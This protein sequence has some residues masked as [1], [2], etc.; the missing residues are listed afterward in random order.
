MFGDGQRLTRQGSLVHVQTLGLEQPGIGG[1]TISWGQDQHISRH[2]VAGPQG[3]RL[4]VAQDT[5]GGGAH[6]PQHLSGS[7]GLPLLPG[8]HR[9]I[10]ADGSRDD[11]G[12]DSLA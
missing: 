11:S 10:D 1:D 2:Q 6:L 9:D 7:A 12:I 3:H 5:S 4:T 8:A